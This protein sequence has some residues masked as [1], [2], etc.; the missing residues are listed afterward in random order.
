MKK[1]SPLVSII[2]VVYN[3]RSTIVQNLNSVISQ[4]YP[5]IEHI[6]IDGASTDGTLQLIDKVKK[7][8]TKLISEPDKGIYDAMNKGLSLAGGEIIGFLNADDAYYDETTISTVVSEMEKTG[9]DSCYGDLIY[10]ARKDPSKVI[11]YWKSYPFDPRFFHR[12]WHPPH[13]TFFV[14]RWVYEVYGGFNLQFRIAA[15][16]ELMLRL[17]LKHRIST[18]YIPRVLVKM[19]TGGISNRNPLNILKANLECYKAWRYN[20]L[21]ADLLLFLAKPSFKLWQI[22]RAIMWAKEKRAR[23]NPEF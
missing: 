9:S 4:T 17:L 19:R 14:R 8:V 23:A 10:V 18:H 1:D 3:S 22:A 21:P 16:Y 20:G 7:K 15:D 2:T 6:I 5:H 12:G 11:R 13:P